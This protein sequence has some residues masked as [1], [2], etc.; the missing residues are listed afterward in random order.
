[1][2][3]FRRENVSGSEVDAYELHAKV[4]ANISSSSI[5]QAR[6]EELRNCKRSR[7]KLVENQ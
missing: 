5:E 1:M 7:G 6:M 4:L 3:S 2:S